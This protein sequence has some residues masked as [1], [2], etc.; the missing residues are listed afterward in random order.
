MTARP[1]GTFT[2]VSFHAHPDDEALLTGGT[3]ARAA[4]DGHRVV[5]VVATAGEAG[6][7]PDDDRPTLGRRRSQELDASARAIGAA[8]VELLGYA[9]SGS[10]GPLLPG[11]FAAVDV[12]VAAIRLAAILDEEGA[13]AI[14]VYDAAGGYGHRDHVQV[15][16]VG[17]RAAEIAGTPLVLEATVDRGRI[18]RV[19]RVLRHL[20]RVIPMPELPETAG[21]F[22]AR[23]DLTH[24]VDVRRHLDAKRSALAAHHSQAGGGPR[25]LALLL[26]LPRPL[27]RAVLGR[28]WFREVGRTPDGPLQ[29][30][31]FA[32]LRDPRVPGARRAA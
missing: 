3:L 22:T 29:D 16:R 14:T 27:A 21:A 30:D 19:V 8:R 24:E 4:A 20:A 1:D 28:E 6:L 7:A 15:H 11:S 32:T 9:D 25:T 31:I 13:D 18:E 2:V 5:L 12:E 26:R 17:L 23:A 10:R